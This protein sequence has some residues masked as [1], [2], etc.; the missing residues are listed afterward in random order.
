MVFFFDANMA[1]TELDAPRS[2]IE[3]EVRRIQTLLRA[4]RLDEALAAAEGLRAE[5]P[6]NRDVLYMIAVSLRYLKRIPE[7]L[8]VLA[9]LERR[10]PQY[11]RLFQERGHCHVALCRPEPAT[12]A[13]LRAVTRSEER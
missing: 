2:T 1:A 9:E 4:G 13:F 5:V 11:S 10:H 6:E 3:L 8:E 12:R 7:A